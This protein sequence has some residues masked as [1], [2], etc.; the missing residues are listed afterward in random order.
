[1][2]AE[3]T[4]YIQKLPPWQIAVCEALRMMIFETI[5]GV[6][7]RI[8]YGKPH[9]LKNGHYAAV[10]SPAKDKISFMLFNALEL[11]E[12]KG[13]L[14]SASSP[15]RKIV[16]ITEGQAVDYQQLAGFLKQTSATL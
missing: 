5:P 3:V 9:Y 13:I 2:T 10:I 1:M 6:E 11:K 14:K 16:A 7:E 4:T 15:E 8:Q 12:I